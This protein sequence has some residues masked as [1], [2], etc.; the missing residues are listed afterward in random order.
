MALV[1]LGVIVTLMSVSRAV[2]EIT[3]KLLEPASLSP[4]IDEITIT[5]ID[6]IPGYTAGQ[7]KVVAVGMW[8]D[9]T[10]SEYV[11][12]VLDVNAEGATYAPSLAL[13][14][15][16]SHAFTSMPDPKIALYDTKYLVSFAHP[17]SGAVYAF[18]QTKGD[19]NAANIKMV[20][21]TPPSAYASGGFKAGYI[22]GYMG[23]ISTQAG[24]WWAASVNMSTS[25]LLW[26][27]S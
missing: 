7:D 3:P 19:S 6:S 27:R 18:E 5:D 1:V 26:A 4:T 8:H 10:N 21:V 2:T 20:K 15:Q 13:R 17:T 24:V 22:T 11:L 9:K 25:A 12:F 16:S 23:L 14:M